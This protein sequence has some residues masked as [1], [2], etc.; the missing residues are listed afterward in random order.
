MRVSPVAWYFDTVDDVERWA[1]ISARVTHDHPEGIRGAQATASAAFLARK[2]SGRRAIRH[3]ISQRYGYDLS[4]SLDQIR[5]TY[6]HVES[7]QETVPEA[8]T[9]FAESDGFEDAIRG[10]VSLGGDSDTLGAIT[11]SI[12]EGYYG[13]SDD[14]R[15]QARSRLDATI[16]G[17]IDRFDAEVE[18][19]DS[20]R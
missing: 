17:V 14:L 19:R 16:L 7:S 3:Y 10:A 11:G 15:A 20:S 4:R 13:I 9:A 8:I 12:A 18:R 5:P 6:H 1:A 2:G